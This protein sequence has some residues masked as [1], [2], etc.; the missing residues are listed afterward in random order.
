M[1]V[2]VRLLGL[3]IVADS[4]DIR[5]FFI[6]LNIPRG[7]VYI[8]GGLYGEAFIAFET[9]EDARCALNLAGRAIK[10]S[11]IHLS[12]SSEAEMRYAFE[13]N[14]IATNQ[15]LQA[16][17]SVGFGN[18]PASNGLHPYEPHIASG[19]NASSRVPSFLYMHGM[20]LKAT[21]VDIK[22]Y[23]RGLDVEDVI[24][25]K[26]Q[27][28]IR[29]GNAV[30]KF[31]RST[32][33]RVGLGYNTLFMGTCQ[34]SLLPANEKEWMKAGGTCKKEYSPPISPIS[35][36][37]RTHSRS[38]ARKNLKRQVYIDE[39]YVHLQNL[40]YNVTKRD[41]KGYFRFADIEDSQISFLLDKS[42]KKTREAFVMFK[43][44]KD[45]KRALDLHNVLFLGRPISIYAIP[46]KAMLDLIAREGKITSRSR[47][48]S[49]SKDLPKR[50]SRESTSGELNC[51]YLRNFPFDVTKS[52]IKIFFTGFPVKED[53]IF[54][55]S[56]DKG[57]G[58]GEALVKFPTKKEASS[59]E[60]L[61]RRKFLGTEILLRCIAE[62]QMKAFGVDVCMTHSAA[63][64]SS[65]Q[66]LDESVPLVTETDDPPEDTGLACTL[67]SGDMVPSS[68][69]SQVTPAMD[70]EEV[71]SGLPETCAPGTDPP[72]DF[73]KIEVPG[74]DTV[75]DTGANPASDLPET[76]SLGANLA[77]GPP[78]SEAP[79]ASPASG[80]PESEAPGA[81]PALGP[82]ESEA[83]GAGPV[84]GPPESEAPGASPASGPPESEAPGASP[85][86][87]PPESEAPG[88][89][90]A[91]DPPET[92]APGANPASGPPETKAPGANPASGPPQTEAPGANP[93][94]G[95]PQTEA[96]GANPVSGPP[97]T[98]APGANPAS[99]PT[100]TEAVGANSVSDPPQTEAPGA[101]PASDSPTSCI[102]ERTH[103]LQSTEEKPVL[104][105][106]NPSVAEK[107]ANKEVSIP[108]T[109]QAGGATSD[110]VSDGKTSFVT[111]FL[112]NLPRTVTVAEIFDFFHGYKVSSVN[113]KNIEA[114]TATVRIQNYKEALSAV[115][116]LNTK[117]VGNK[118]VVLS[119]F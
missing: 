12:L 93:A 98:E 64:D 53:D 102:T 18:G 22:D 13:V 72:S 76:N 17:S 37:K 86:S 73:P 19:G 68:D 50:S 7:G 57:V 38:P 101:N 117:L 115:N 34:V 104:D 110:K 25:L 81:S 103:S 26:F 67:E 84:S 75:S 71:V 96:P 112:R 24:F 46:K 3:P 5:N 80:P 56:D 6:G 40:S 32:D 109:N 106:S 87:G 11:V 94:S 20:P 44:G 51:I 77:A 15:P 85:A 55:L 70:V 31:G 47:E 114:G 74:T 30:V 62:E 61:H 36:R 119:L 83:P 91:S 29:N 82:P 49:I 16:M 95:P 108:R 89:S 45:Y 78:E 90:P 4:Y 54:L 118:R 63:R 69:S 105:V 60:K 59:A 43:R 21:K 23:F 97:Q 58:L 66:S 107:P 27:N 99:D 52:D 14:R 42:G 33:A 100:E 113:L 65:S 35:G 9:F 79:G 92:E 88:A 111:I 2:I 28:G 10:N 39:Y 41:I 8:I 48:R 1:S 116:K